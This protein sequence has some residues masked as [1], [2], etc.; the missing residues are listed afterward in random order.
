MC[1]CPSRVCVCAIMTIF[2]HSLMG[3]MYVISAP[4]F[5]TLFQF[6]NGMVRFCIC[7]RPEDFQLITIKKKAME[8]LTRANQSLEREKIEFQPGFKPRVYVI[9][10]PLQCQSLSGSIGK[11]I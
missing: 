7:C 8:M 11:S 9:Y 2:I 4:S 3:Y 6:R 10:P 5:K 1:V